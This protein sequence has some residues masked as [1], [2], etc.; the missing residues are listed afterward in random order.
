MEYENIMFRFHA[1]SGV[2][3]LRHQVAITIFKSHNLANGITTLT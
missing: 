3:K 1:D 2:M